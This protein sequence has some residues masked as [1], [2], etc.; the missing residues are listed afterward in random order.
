MEAAQRN[1]PYLVFGFCSQISPGNSQVGSG[2][3]HQPLQRTDTV[4]IWEETDTSSKG[5]P[6]PAAQ[7]I[8]RTATVEGPAKPHKHQ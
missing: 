5:R 2:M 4:K 6:E 7:D 3:L 8:D 1:G